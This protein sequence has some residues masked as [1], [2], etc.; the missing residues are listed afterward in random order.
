[1]VADFPNLNCSRI[2]KIW[3]SWS[4]WTCRNSFQCTV[5]ELLKYELYD[6]TELVGT[7]FRFGFDYVKILNTFV[8]C[9]ATPLIVYNEQRLLYHF[10]DIE[11]HCFDK[12]GSVSITCVFWKILSFLT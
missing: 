12:A 1:M 9:L 7:P 4:S 6:L 2:V 3:I 8:H 5:S 11:H 10:I